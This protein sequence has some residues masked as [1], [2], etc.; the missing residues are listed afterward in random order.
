MAH[1]GE[2]Q[3]QRG[4]HSSHQSTT[5]PFFPTG[6]S[7][8]VR[9]YPPPHGKPESLDLPG[10]LSPGTGGT[11]RQG[12]RDQDLR[13]TQN[14]K[15]YF[16]FLQGCQLKWEGPYSYLGGGV[17]SLGQVGKYLL[18]LSRIFLL[19]SISQEVGIWECKE[20]IST[21]GLGPWTMFL[22]GIL[23]GYS[24]DSTLRNASKTGLNLNQGPTSMATL[25]ESPSILV[26]WWQFPEQ[27]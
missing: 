7:T 18:Y 15:W 1:T 25:L 16:R 10:R 27:W 26:K 23:Y 17:K 5:H 2:F 20:T 4:P 14:H 6:Q 24:L 19:V 9:D 22:E 3:L 21:M 12:V 13:A 8:C 11:W